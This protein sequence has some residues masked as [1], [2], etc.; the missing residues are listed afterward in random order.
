MKKMLIIS[1]VVAG[2]LSSHAFAV[3]I[4]K[5]RVV[6]HKEWSTSGAAASYLPGHPLQRNT[7]LPGKVRSESWAQLN[8]KT[9]SQSAKVGEPVRM[10]NDGRVTVYNNTD[11]SQL[12]QLELH[13]CAENNVPD[14]LECVFIQDTVELQPD[15]SY[16]EPVVPA[17]TIAYN[18]PGAYEVFVDGMLEGTGRLYGTSSGIITVS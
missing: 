14:T 5:G 17:L 3:Q 16:S 11:S 12:Y 6:K 2:V 7:L 1:L 15:G 8:V 4:N 10:I 18:K 9:I 13:V